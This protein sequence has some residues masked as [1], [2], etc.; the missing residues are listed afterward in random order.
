MRGPTLG[1]MPAYSEEDKQEGVLLDGVR[2]GG[3]AEKAGL[4][5]GDRIT[6]IRDMPVKNLQ[7][8]MTIMGGVKRGDKLE[9]TI[10]RDGKTLKLTVPLE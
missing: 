1:I 10:V 9:L 4:K 8:Y 2:P 3:P 6:A 5:T 7:N